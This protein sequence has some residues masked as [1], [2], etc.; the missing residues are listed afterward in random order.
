MQAGSTATMAKPDE[1]RVEKLHREAIVID[2]SIVID[3]VPEHFDR[4]KRGGVTA[5][6]HT[7]TDPY[8]DLLTSLKEIEFCRRWIAENAEHALLVR[9]VTDIHEAKRSGREGVIFGPQNTE[10]IGFDLDLLGTFH[11]LGV[12]I[13]QL[14]YQRQNWI[15]SGCGEKADSG[16]TQY[17]RKFVAEMD[18]LGIL[19]DLSHCS[20]Q[21]AADA[22]EVSKN[23]VIFSHA[24]PYTLSPHIRAKKDDNIKAVAATGGLIGITG[25]SPY[26]YYPD[27][28]TTQPTTERYVEHI[29]YVADLVGIDHVS[30]GLDYDETFTPQKR[31]EGAKKHGALLGQWP[32]PERRCKDI[33]D[34][35]DMIS[36]TRAL[37]AA[38]FSDTDVKKVIG[39]NLMRVFEAVW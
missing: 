27:K 18:A 16:L 24:H 35:G 11:E 32:W 6:N 13:L 15:G 38:G 1:K 34:A 2:G 31:E 19:V 22:A 37:V 8:A 36:I 25:L 5:V 14:T 12:R 39:G 30:V 28:P 21:T 20:A 3:M 9:S 4:V 23:P 33:D 10:M 26:L 7:V 17:G 29:T